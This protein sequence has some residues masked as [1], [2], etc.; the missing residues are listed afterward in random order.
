MKKPYFPRAIFAV[1]MISLFFF[2]GC[3]NKEDKTEEVAVQEPAAPVSDSEFSKNTIQVGLIASD[4]DKTLDFYTNVIGM[5]KTGGFDIN[6]EIGRKTGLTGGATFSVSILKLEDSEDATQWKIMSF[7]KDATHPEQKYIQDDTGMQYITIF[8]KSMKPFLERIEK[9]G[10]K[11][12]GDTPFTLA[13]DQEFVLLQ[14]PDG[15]FI[16]LIGPK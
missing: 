6:E 12:L 4:L 2:Q 1:C 3:C 15:V 5:K 7:N 10:V 11:L 8:V 13:P 14:D 16:E 9:H